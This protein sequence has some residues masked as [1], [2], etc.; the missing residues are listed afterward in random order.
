MDQKIKCK[1]RHRDCYSLVELNDTF[2]KMLLYIFNEK[3]HFWLHAIFRK[4]IVLLKGLYIW[5]S[6]LILKTCDYFHSKIALSVPTNLSNL[7]LAT[8]SSRSFI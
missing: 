5:T 8:G 4:Q 7:V 1:M 3:M 2:V 6:N